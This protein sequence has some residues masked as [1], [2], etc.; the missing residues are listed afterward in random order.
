[1][2]KTSDEVM[3][4]HAQWKVAL[5]R[6]QRDQQNKLAGNTVFAY[7]RFGAGIGFSLAPTQHNSF[8]HLW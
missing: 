4:V 1:M 6:A 2:R 5:V 7:N 3:K 8:Y